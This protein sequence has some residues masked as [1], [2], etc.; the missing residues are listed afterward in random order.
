MLAAD[1][2][3]ADGPLALWDR[4]GGAH[5]RLVG[6]AV[7]DLPVGAPVDRHLDVEILDQ[8]DDVDADRP[9]IELLGY[10]GVPPGSGVAIAVDGTIAAVVPGVQGAYGA[11]AVHALLW[12]DALS[13][14]RNE[15]EAFV[16][17]GTADAPTLRPLPVRP[18]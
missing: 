11:T 6:R 1:P 10:T 12:P 5:G 17:E 9:P 4:T 3:P 16:I 8:W 7:D 2:I 18:G 13:E 14:G 15:I